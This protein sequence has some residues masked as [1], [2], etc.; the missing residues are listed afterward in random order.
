MV[1]VINKDNTFFNA[2]IVDMI[3]AVFNIRFNAVFLWHYMYY[4]TNN[5][6][7][8]VSNDAFRY[9]FLIFRLYYRHLSG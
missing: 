4:A 7:V 8:Q 9:T 6:I 5:G 2:T 1:L 3:Y